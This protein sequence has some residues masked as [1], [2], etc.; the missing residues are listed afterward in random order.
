[1]SAAVSPPQPGETWQDR[2][3]R[4]G[5][6]QVLVL[7][8]DEHFVTVLGRQRSRVRTAAFVRRYCRTGA[9]S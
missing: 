6:R 3:E 8:A 5:V 1:M 4:G 7:S 9:P 2:D